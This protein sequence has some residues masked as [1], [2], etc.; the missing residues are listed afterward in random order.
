MQHYKVLRRIASEFGGIGHQDYVQVRWM[1]TGVE[2]PRDGETVAAVIALAA[3]D[4]DP[5]LAERRESGGEEF[6]APV[7]R[8]FHQN[9]SRYAGFDGGAVDSTHLSGR[10]NFAQSIRVLH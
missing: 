9:D 1:E 2:L 4:Y 8:I 6:H 5:L 10:Q 3:N 7:R